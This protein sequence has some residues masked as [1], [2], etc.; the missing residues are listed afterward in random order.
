DEGR[1]EAREPRARALRPAPVSER[2]AAVPPSRRRP[3]PSAGQAP[4]VRRPRVAGLRNRPADH[5]DD[6]PDDLS[7]DQQDEPGRE[8]LSGRLDPGPPADTPDEPMAEDTGVKDLRAPF[9]LADESAE[10]DE[11]AEDVDGD[12]DEDQVDADDMPAPVRR[13][14]GKRRTAGVT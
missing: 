8:S 1:L 12:Y 10:P 5:E 2:T 11:V 13:P 14:A 3:H 7:N 9:E 6:L 4:P